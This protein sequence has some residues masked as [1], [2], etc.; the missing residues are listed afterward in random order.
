MERSATNERC[1]PGDRFDTADS[2]RRSARCC[3]DA[4]RP[5]AD[6]GSPVEVCTIYLTVLCCR[7]NSFTSADIPVIKKTTGMFQGSALRQNAM[8]LIAL[9]ESRSLTWDVTVHSSHVD[10]SALSAANAAAVRKV[11]KYVCPDCTR[12]LGP[13]CE[14]DLNLHAIY[15]GSHL[16]AFFAHDV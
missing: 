9:S 6:T 16:T 10:G 13:V 15:S 4:W 14:A 3:W 12:L 1:P 2:W 8:T 11:D 7:Y 5:G